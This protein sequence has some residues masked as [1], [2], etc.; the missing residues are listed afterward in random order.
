METKEKV[1]VNIKIINNKIIV[2]PVIIHITINDRIWCLFMSGKLN[3][4]NRNNKCKL[5]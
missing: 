1:A 2:K 4:C 3:V 5:L